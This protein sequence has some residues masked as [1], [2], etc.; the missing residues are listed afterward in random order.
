MAA[1]LA[2]PWMVTPAGPARSLGAQGVSTA[3]I[4]GIVRSAGGGQYLD[5]AHVVV[6]NRASGYSLSTTTR[7]G[8]FFALGLE[9]GGPYSVTVRRLGF[10]PTTRDSLYLTL[11]EPRALEIVLEPAAQT[12]AGIRVVAPTE[13]VG[14]GHAG[15]TTTISDSLLHRL[16]SLNR[17]MYD[18]A[19]L[20]PQV[21]MRF[22]GVSSGASF[23]LNS[24]LIDGV[25]DRQVG[26]NQVMGGARGGKS[27]PLDAVKEYQVLLS[28]Y[29]ARY[30]D[31][32]GLLVN[33]VT[34]SGTNELHGSVFGYVRNENLARSSGFL[35]GSSYERQQFGFTLGGPLVRDRMHFLVAPEFQ[36]HDEP[37]TG[38]YVGQPPNA[39]VPLP[40]SAADVE[41]FASL[42]R[43]HGIDPGHGGRVTSVN[44]VAAFFGRLDLSLPEWRSRLA[45]RHTYSDVERTQFARSSTGRFPLSSSSFAI[46]FTKRST[47][48]Q[49]FTQPTARV[50]NELLV[51]Y[52][53]IP[54]E[55]SRYTYAPTIMVSVPNVTG[56]GLPA[57]LVAGPPEMGQGTKI[58]NTSVEIADH[59]SF[60]IDE[61]H[62]LSMG[63]RNE[64]FR[65]SGKTI[66]GSYGLWT[67]SD[68]DALERGEALSYQVSRDFGSAATPLNGGQLSAYVND[69]WRPTNGLTLSAGVRADVLSFAARPDL[70]AA[71][72]SVFGRRTSDFPDTHLT[73]SPRLGFSWEPRP[74]GFTRVRG[75]AGLFAG[76]PPLG[77]LRSPL[78]R[79]GTGIRVLRCSALPAGPQIVPDFSADAG[80]V[81]NTC[82]NGK[83]YTSGGVDLVDRHLRMAE[84]ARAS[85]AVDRRLPWDVVATVEALYTKNRSDFVLVNMNLLGPQG[86]DRNGRVMYGALG[87]SGARPALAVPD[88]LPEVI[89]LRNQSRN[90]SWSLT[91]QL[92]KRFSNRVEA[93][94]SYTYSVVR[95][96]Q[97]LADNPAGNAVIDHWAGSRAVAARHD[98]LS[99]TISSFDIPHRVVFAATYAAPWK[100][101]PTDVSVTYIGESGVRYTYVD[102]SAT[103]GFGDLNADGTSAND[104]IYVPR[105]AADTTEI[106]FDTRPGQ[107]VRGQQAAFEEFIA[108]TPC[109]RRQRGR[110]VERNSCL[111]PWVHTS[112]VSLRQ[113]L[114]TWGHRV[115]L[116]LDVFNVLNLLS[117]RWGLVR[118]PNVNALEHVGQTS[119][120]PNVSRS[121]FRFNPGL[122]RYS[123]AN[124]ESS[125]QLQLAARYSF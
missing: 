58:I 125:Y 23:R 28:P 47:A 36:R 88:T 40:V 48:A 25:S 24:Y 46:R 99:P 38:P 100:R 97:S 50:F 59:V 89:D 22:A 86:V 54:N 61:R 102:S 44:P 98:D 118:A 83:P 43:A 119:G 13:P 14:R 5:D 112:Q 57:R 79:D 65:Y 35:G 21:S 113:G 105:N 18:F 32:A 49:L 42:L 109:L 77:W 71:I 74:N 55:A 114:P 26:G 4:T 69:E 10:A 9:V 122:Q 2:P 72:D 95:D 75:G 56:S 103:P 111:S 110:I 67:F 70:N 121:I 29:D 64:W 107:D 15:T 63:V 52:S 104:P 53:T 19:R 16:P 85:L 60:R 96:V 82:A 51:A 8:R 27:M 17:D 31:F 106:M 120:A 1:V 81:P 41:R 62:A 73:W 76:R 91:G 123:T 84:A 78:R 87:A 115:T 66:P 90:Y 37:A 30:G 3:S 33:A 93:R 7:S 94:A 116:Q 12:L 124:A 39:P 45:L 92:T 34:K 80:F 108:G 117:P 101:W 6:V 20:V 68:L 11:G